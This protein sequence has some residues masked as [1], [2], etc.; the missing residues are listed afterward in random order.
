MEDFDLRPSWSLAVALKDAIKEEMAVAYHGRHRQ[1]GEND[2]ALALR[3]GHQSHTSSAPVSSNQGSPVS[4]QRD[5]TDVL[6]GPGDAETTP[7]GSTV[8][9]ANLFAAAAGADNL[10]CSGDSLTTERE[11]QPSAPVTVA[12]RVAA[13]EEEAPTTR[14]VNEEKPENKYSLV[15][16]RKF[17]PEDRDVQGGQNEVS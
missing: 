1:L 14:C 8:S 3:Q 16:Q 10:G 13:T 6:R 7:E 12:G 4:Q 9:R 5:P 17:I 15:C 2:P 11:P